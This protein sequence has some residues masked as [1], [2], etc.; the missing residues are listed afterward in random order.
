M[1]PASASAE[2][3][4]GEFNIKSLYFQK[5]LSVIHRESWLSKA[6]TF[7]FTLLRETGLL[8]YQIGGVDVQL[9]NTPAWVGYEYLADGEVML[10]VK[11][12][13]KW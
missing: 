12:K 5:L 1:T 3:L 9:L 11:L 7:E 8:R 2:P 13:Q 6:P 4:L 10:I